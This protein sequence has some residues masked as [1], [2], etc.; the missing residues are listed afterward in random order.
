MKKL[1]SFYVTTFCYSIVC[2]S[3]HMTTDVHEHGSWLALG[4]WRLARGTGVGSL[5]Q[6]DHMALT[7]TYPSSKYGWRGDEGLSCDVALQWDLDKLST[8]GDA[9]SGCSLMAI[10]GGGASKARAPRARVKARQN[11]RCQTERD[12]DLREIQGDPRGP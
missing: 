3:I 5:L 7:E 9:S 12:R 1:E 11:E 6:V 8:K 10:S 2:T 4:A